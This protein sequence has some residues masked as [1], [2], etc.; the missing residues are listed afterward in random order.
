[1]LFGRQCKIDYRCC[2]FQLT[3]QAVDD[4]NRGR[5]Y[6]RDMAAKNGVPTLDSVEE[7][8]NCAA[9]ILLKQLKS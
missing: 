9:D 1:M 6:L 2:N 7:A 3:K 8:V 5:A 4:Y